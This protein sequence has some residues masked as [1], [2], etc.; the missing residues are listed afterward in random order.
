MAST[1]IR[2]LDFLKSKVDQES[3]RIYL[4]TGDDEYL[5]QLVVKKLENQFV[6][7]DFRD[8]NFRRIDCSKK[9]LAGEVSSVL[10]ELPTLVDSRLVFLHRIVTLSKSVSSRLADTFESDIAPGTV[11]VVSAGGAI[12]DSKLWP[13]LQKRGAIVDC[14]LKETEIDQLL[15]SFCKKAGKKAE[16]AAFSRL[17]ERVGGSVRGLVSHLERCLLSLSDGE[18]L[19][20]EQVDRLV[21]FSAG[22]AMWK[23]TAAIGKKNHR[24][25]LK[26]LD[27][28][29]DRG[30]NP[31]SILGYLNSYIT[32]LVQTGGLMKRL[33]SAAA[34]AQAL[35]RKKEYQVKKTLQ[36]LRTWSATDLEGAFEV[37]ARADF[38]SKGGAGGGD[39]RLLLQMLVLKLCSRRQR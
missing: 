19:T 14:A 5:Q 33:G 25:A 27:H 9:T 24:E 1:K 2:I 36:E 11:L 39:P 10:S 4:L 38:K 18:S 26:I 17:R 21:P 35:P 3:L 28:Q 12:K 31:G 30:E 16:R 22:V 8:F 6:D 20:P 29:L 13:F 23:M 15:E 7:P 34:V 32:S 37:M